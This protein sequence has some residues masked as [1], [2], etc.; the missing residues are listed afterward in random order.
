MVFI[1]TYYFYLNAIVSI[2]DDDESPSLKFE[3]E[4]RAKTAPNPLY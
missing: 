3:R 1:I 2:E 4:Q